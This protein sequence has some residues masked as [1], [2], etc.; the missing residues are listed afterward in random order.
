MD[1]YELFFENC[2]ESS[3]FPAILLTATNSWIKDYSKFKPMAGLLLKSYENM[4]KK[5][6][7]DYNE[8]AKDIL[9][10]AQPNVQQDEKFQDLKDCVEQK[11]II[12]SLT[13]SVKSIFRLGDNSKHDYE[14]E[15]RQKRDNRKK[16]Q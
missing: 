10:K 15:D 5:Q 2:K 9:K 6:Q 1:S 7:K 13:S 11:S 14:R 3:N 4:D 12:A 16:D 8:K